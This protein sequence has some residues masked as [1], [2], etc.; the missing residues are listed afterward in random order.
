[1][2]ALPEFPGQF[3]YDYRVLVETGPCNFS[4]DKWLFRKLVDW[5]VPAWEK[6][7]PGHGYRMAKAWTYMAA[8]P[9]SSRAG[10]HTHHANLPLP[11][12][13]TWDWVPYQIPKNQLDI[14]KIGPFPL[15]GAIRPAKI[16]VRPGSRASHRYWLGTTQPYLLALH[17][18]LH[19]P[20]RYPLNTIR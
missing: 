12:A 5:P 19:H 10:S 7:P 11:N 16:A 13:V 17:L 2:S 3:S 9:G 20:I 8:G 15:P 6:I 14:N 4:G 1:M 18:L